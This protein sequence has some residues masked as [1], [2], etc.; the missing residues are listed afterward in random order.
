MWWFGAALLLLWEAEASPSLLWPSLQQLRP[1][2][3]SECD[4]CAAAGGAGVR[5]AP[6]PRMTARSPGWAGMTSPW[7]LLLPPAAQVSTYTF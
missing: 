7:L 1:R 4:L 6:K 5:A 3:T 2:H